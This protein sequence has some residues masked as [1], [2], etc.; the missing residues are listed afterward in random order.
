MLVG[1]LMGET[2]EHHSPSVLTL[3][4]N[5]LGF[6]GRIWARPLFST[7]MSENCLAAG[8][9]VTLPI[10]LLMTRGSL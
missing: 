7:Q 5:V 1:S 4:P 10:I 3:C 9:N 6:S 2:G 8:F